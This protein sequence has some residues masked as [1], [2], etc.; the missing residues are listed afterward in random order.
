MRYN[1]KIIRRRRIKKFSHKFAM[2][3]EVLLS[4]ATPFKW[5]PGDTKCLIDL[6]AKHKDKF[7]SFQKIKAWDIIAQEITG[8][9]GKIITSDQCN[10]K[11]KGLKSMYKKVLDHNSTSGNGRKDWEHFDAMHE[12]LWMKPEINPPATCSTDD[13]EVVN[14]SDYDFCDMFTEEATPRTRTK[15]KTDEN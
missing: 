10:G 7:E 8:I 4:A 11:W 15:R 3:V 5:S 2:E 1:Y 13:T 12:I 14:T 9:R 6:Y